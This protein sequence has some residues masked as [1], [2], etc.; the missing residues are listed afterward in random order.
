MRVADDL[1]GTQ[2]STTANSD[3]PDNDVRDVFVMATGA[4][5]IATDGGLAW[6]CDRDLNCT[7]TFS[8][9]DA[10]LQRPALAAS[11][12][13][14]AAWWACGP[15][16]ACPRWTCAAWPETLA[17]ASTS[18]TARRRARFATTGCELQR[19]Q[20]RRFAPT[21][22]PEGRGG[23]GVS[24]AVDLDVLEDRLVGHGHVQGVGQLGD[25]AAVGPDGVGRLASTRRGP[26][27][28][29]VDGGNV[30]PRVAIV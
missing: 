27:D 21:P 6:D 24:G 12:P 23:A 20:A 8:D 4:I 9:G 5:V 18:A 19:P 13:T 15:S 1:S 28:G 22:L 16:T 26:G 17:T 3:L 7:R 10:G 14:S 30:G 25:V 2:T 11:T 29:A